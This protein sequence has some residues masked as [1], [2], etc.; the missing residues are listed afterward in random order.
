MGKKTRNQLILAKFIEGAG[1]RAVPDL[2]KDDLAVSFGE[3]VLDDLTDDG[4]I[5]EAK[6][7]M[8]E[9]LKSVRHTERKL[10]EWLEEAGRRK[11][12][13]DSGVAADWEQPLLELARKNIFKLN[14]EKASAESA[15]KVLRD[16]I[17]ALIKERR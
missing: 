4:D 11:D 9:Y 14:G 16:H 17:A 13:S 1:L 2:P 5:D 6:S 8:E 12:R 10:S 15:V 7:L 3:K